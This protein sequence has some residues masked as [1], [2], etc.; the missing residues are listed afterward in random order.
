MEE[1]LGRGHWRKMTIRIPKILIWLTVVGLVLMAGAVVTGL[2][3]STRSASVRASEP[4]PVGI[5]AMMSLSPT[6]GG[7]NT[8]VNITG[9]GFTEN[10]RVRIFVTAPSSETTSATPHAEALTDD[11][12]RFSVM[13]QMPSVWPDGTPITDE[14]LVLL[15]TTEDGSMHANAAFDFIP[16]VVQPEITVSPTTG[17]GGTTVTVSSVG[18]PVGSRVLLHLGPP[19]GGYGPT[20]YG[21]GVADANGAVNVAFAMPDNWPDGSRV[22]DEQLEIVAITEDG[23]VRASS[24]FDY[25]PIPYPLITVSP[26]YGGPGT[27]V[28]ITGDGY[29]AGMRVLVK[30]GTSVDDAASRPA[31][32]ETIADTRGNINIPFEMPGSWTNG[33]PI[34]TRD[35]V[36]LATAADQSGYGWMGFAYLSFA[37]PEEPAEEEVEQGTGSSDPAEDTGDEEQPA[38]NQQPAREEQ[39]PAVVAPEEVTPEVEEPVEGE[40]PVEVTPET[41]QEP[42]TVVEPAITLTPAEGEAETPILVTGT[43]F[44]PGVTVYLSLSATDSSATLPNYATAVT[45]AEGSF[46]LT[47]AVPAAWPDETPIEAE[48]LVVSVASE[49]GLSVA[50]AILRFLLAVAG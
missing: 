4:E 15:A 11:Y 46:S 44:P 43:G 8:L 41:E 25:V 45:D 35:V 50:T 29:P 20:V 1:P 26:N 34:L 36:V 42:E 37:A 9:I 13:L 17:G 22:K 21:E 30:T 18:F 28:T 6:Y 16:P 12:G 5:E 40:P 24:G 2:V 48:E 31:H 33:L 23:S 32:V 19:S 49:D 14:T 27:P 10:V 47:F 3:L 7:A 39:P 38:G